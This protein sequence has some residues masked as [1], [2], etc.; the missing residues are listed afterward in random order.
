MFAWLRVVSPRSVR[1][2]G[3]VCIPLLLPNSPPG[4][5]VF[6]SAAAMAAGSSK[7]GGHPVPLTRVRLRHLSS[8]PPK[9]YQYV[10]LQQGNLLARVDLQ[11]LG[12]L[13]Q[14]PLRVHHRPGQDRGPARFFC[15]W[16]YSVLVQ[17]FPYMDHMRI[18]GNG[19]KPGTPNTM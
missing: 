7:P 19:S 15:V 13:G 16:I 10:L 11:C 8:I 5:D 1:R 4:L 9:D 12:C 14:D 6:R 17:H 18:Y 3:A 2:C